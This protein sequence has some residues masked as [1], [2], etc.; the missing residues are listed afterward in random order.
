MPVVVIPLRY[1][2]IT[3]V[4]KGHTSGGTIVSPGGR[5]ERKK[6]GMAVEVGMVKHQVGGV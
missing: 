4:T 1:C 2:M 6:A 5:D 3:K